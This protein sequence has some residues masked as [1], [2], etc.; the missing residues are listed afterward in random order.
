MTLWILYNPSATTSPFSASSSAITTLPT[1]TTRL[2]IVVRGG[3]EDIV[4]FG[5]E[6]DYFNRNNIIHLGLFTCDYETGY[7]YNF[8]KATFARGN[9]EVSVDYRHNF[10]PTGDADRDSVDYDQFNW[11]W[12]ETQNWVR[13]DPVDLIS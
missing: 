6:I 3:V 10:T 9:S 11:Q 12:F 8:N 4:Q 1:F 7:L 2:A 5:P 13:N